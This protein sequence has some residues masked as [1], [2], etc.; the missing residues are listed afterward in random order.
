MEKRISN[1]RQWFRD[2]LHFLGKTVMEFNDAA[3]D[4]ELSSDSAARRNP[5]EPSRGYLRPPGAVPEKEFTTLCNKCGDC[6]KACPEEVLFPSAGKEEAGGYPV[7]NP[8]AKACFLCSPMHCVNACKTGALKPVEDISKVEIGKA[9]I[10]PALCKARE[11]DECRL[12]HDFCPLS[13]KAVIILGG[14]PSIQA[15]ECVGCGQC[16]YH[17]FHE[18]GRNAITTLPRLA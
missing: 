11:G 14:V 6:I 13:G 16:E 15:L 5:L 2:G 8:R 9:R 1:R 4:V 18:A 17:C 3:K 10:N 7:F 12:C